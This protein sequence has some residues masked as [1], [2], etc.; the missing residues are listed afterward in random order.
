MHCVGA[1]DQKISTTS[2]DTLRGRGQDGRGTG[3][4][5]LV[6]QLHDGF[7]VNTAKSQGL[8]PVIW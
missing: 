5:A 2:L 3:P 7:K 6:L 4:V 1:N 8:G